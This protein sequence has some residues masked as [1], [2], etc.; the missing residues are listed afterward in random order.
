MVKNM[1]FLNMKNRSEELSN[2]NLLQKWRDD[3][4]GCRHRNHLNNAGA[5]LMPQPVIDAVHEHLNLEARIGGYEAADREKDQIEKAYQSVADLIQTQPSNIA[6]VENA[7]VAT[8]QAL[9]AFDFRRGDAILTTNVDYSSNQ[10]MLL[11]LAKRFGVEIVRV[12]DL[13]S[14]GVDPE[15]VRKLTSKKRPKLVLMSWIPTNSGLVQ[16][17]QA[18][19]EICREAEVPFVLDA[20][21]AVGQIPV[22]VETLKCDF[23]AATARKFLRGPRGIGFLYVS[24]RIL[25]RSMEPLFPDTHGAA[26]TE[27]NKYTLEPDARRF[28]N[29]EFSHALILGLGAAAEYAM[30]VGIDVA[31]NRSLKLAEYVRSKLKEMPCARIFD[32]GENQCAIVSVGFDQH[33]PEELVDRLREKKINTSAASRTAGVIDMRSKGVESILRISPHYYNT[34]DEADE[35]LEALNRIN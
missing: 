5:A 34:M 25:E 2:Q 15:S 21:Q 23:L 14:G 6:M 19:G 29:W 12:D 8:S 31:A 7:T 13:S 27:P 10:I 22:D 1:Y 11:S 32:R 18:V 30:E 17:A 3:T 28:E 35:L 20:C 16:D 24:N 33:Q 26:W 9:S 4:P